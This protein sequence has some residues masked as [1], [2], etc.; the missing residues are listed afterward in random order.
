[1]IAFVIYWGNFDG[2]LA[3]YRGA[4]VYPRRQY[5]LPSWSNNNPLM[6]Q[7]W[8]SDDITKISSLDFK[9][10]GNMHNHIVY[11]ISVLRM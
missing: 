9:C 5:R 4:T 1:M 11:F 8:H 2:K 7:C 6:Q 3:E 10:K